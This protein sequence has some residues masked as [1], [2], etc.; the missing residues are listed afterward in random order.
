MSGPI[1]PCVAIGV[2]SYANQWYNGGSPTDVK[3]LLF[4]GIA[5]L[6][7]T[8]FAAIPGMGPTA[9]ALGWT[10]FVGMLI[11]PVQKPSPAQN[12]LKITGSK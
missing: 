7:L 10:A 5:G 9:T 3:P 12:L 6:L 8:G 11:S 2:V 1:T 4:A